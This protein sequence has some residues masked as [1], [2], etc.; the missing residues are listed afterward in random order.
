MSCGIKKTSVVQLWKLDVLCL[1]VHSGAVPG[2]GDGW[3][4]VC[5]AKKRVVVSSCLTELMLQLSSCQTLLPQ[6]WWDPELHLWGTQGCPW[7][8]IPSLRDFQAPWGWYSQMHLFTFS[9][10]LLFNFCTLTWV[11]N[12]VRKGS[13]VVIAFS[14][15]F[16]LIL[17]LLPRI[18][19]QILLIYFYVIITSLVSSRG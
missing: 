12:I 4:G 17:K 18:L 15:T 16:V 3:W 1:P 8:P 13:E 19:W 2:Y 7:L 10:E 14:Q 11:G 6:P 9:S 5:L